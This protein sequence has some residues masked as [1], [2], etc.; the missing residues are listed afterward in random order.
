MSYIE[1]SLK[2]AMDFGA[3]RRA[4][5]Y[6]VGDLDEVNFGANEIRGVFFQIERNI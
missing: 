3:F 1:T 2:L 5:F 4:G 6:A